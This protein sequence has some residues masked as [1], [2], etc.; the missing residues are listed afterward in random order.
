MAADAAAPARLRVVA[1]GDF[2][3]DAADEA[4]KLGRLALDKDRFE[5][6]LARVRPTLHLELA[7]AGGASRPLELVFESWRDF[8]P[9]GVAA[10][11]PW[12]RGLAEARALAQRA[13]RSELDAARFRRD[14]AGL[15]PPALVEE[16]AG[17]LEGA[18][19]GA[20]PA[21]ERPAARPA[22]PPEPAAGSP[23]D[24]VDSL[25]DMVGGRDEGG[26]ESGDARARRAL[27]SILPR[28][29]ARAAPGGAAPSGAVALLDAHLERGLREV[30]GHPAFRRLEAAW[31]G[32]RLLVDRTDFRK[33]IDLELVSATLDDAP[34]AVAALVEGEDPDVVV[35]DYAFDASARDLERAQALAGAAQEAQTPVVAAVAPAFFGLDSWRDLARARAPY[36]IFDE[37]AYAAWRSFRGD[38]RARWLVLTANRVA[39]R[40]PYGPDGERSRELGYTDPTGA[41]LTGSGA[42]AVASVLVRAFAR[43]GACVQISGTRNG[44][45]PDLPLV[46]P[47]GGRPVPVEG[48]LDDDRREDLERVGLAVVQQYQRDIAFVGALRTFRKPERYPDAE[49]SADAAQHV[50]LAYQLFASRFVKFLGRSV[51]ELIGAGSADEAAGR[52]RDAVVAFVSTPQY[53]LRPDHVGI[54]T[55]PNADDASLTDVTLR[56][57]P[58]LVVGGRPVNVM[59]QFSV[60]L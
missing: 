35:A 47:E 18:S 13:A 56:I 19:G 20:A 10:R 14:A 8:Q 49:A 54:A 28:R 5:P 11:V 41:G 6:V 50:T 31:R 44:L 48:V 53:E 15:L 30:L 52:L 45:V 34:R 57:Q 59:L 21:E 55:G 22:P 25:L 38:E 51:P 1:L 40:A 4:A 37:P 36:G 60:R 26:G 23:G 9:A 17:Q 3:G 2:A 29:A 42:W 33:P 27:D 43:T 16:L 12:L 32:L 39:L 46:A 7:D 24:A 58:D